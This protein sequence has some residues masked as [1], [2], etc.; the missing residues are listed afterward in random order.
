MVVNY[1]AF[2][3]RCKPAELVLPARILILA[4][5]VKIVYKIS[6]YYW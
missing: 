3:G 5:P 2:E 6:L 1:I 4:R